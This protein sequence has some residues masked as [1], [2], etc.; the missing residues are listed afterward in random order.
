MLIAALGPNIPFPAYGVGTAL[1]KRDQSKFQTETVDS[2]KKA[3]QNGFTHIDCAEL[4]GNE[5]EVGVALK[6]LNIPREKLFITSK[7]SSSVEDISA[8]LSTSLK[9]LGLSYLDLFLIHAPKYLNEKNIPFSKGWEAMET[10]LGQGRV[11]AI[12]VSNFYVEDLEKIMETAKIPPR[13]D[14]IEFHPQVFVRS[15]SLL[16]YCKSKHIIVEGYSSL[17]PLTREPEGTVSKLAKSLANK[18]NVSDSLILLAWSNAQ[19][20]SPVTTTS[21]VERMKHYLTYKTVKLEQAD[22]DAITKAGEESS[23]PLHFY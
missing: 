20:V 14:Q 5:E 2:V 7:V 16:D 15:K 3:I 13:V 11:H 17:R 18:Y 4:Y 23:R 22:I 8:A 9:K 21:K 1:Y 12:G 19:G 6:D 10:E